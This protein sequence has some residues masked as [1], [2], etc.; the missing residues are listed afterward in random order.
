MSAYP[1]WRYF[2]AFEPPPPWIEPLVGV[3]L[4]HRSSFD[5]R[6]AHDEAMKSDLVLE[7]LIG[8]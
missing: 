5:S 1:D 2:P 7:L 6:E 3:F 8:Y 4:A